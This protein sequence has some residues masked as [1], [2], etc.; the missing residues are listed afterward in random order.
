[1]AL[2]I[3]GKTRRPICGEV[4]ASESET[5]SFPAFLRPTHPLFKYSDAVFHAT[6]FAHSPDRDTVERLYQRY[7]VIWENRPK[8]IPSVAEIEA[9]GKKAF[10]EFG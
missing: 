1:M 9:W 6:C 4:I 10:D 3:S 8:D 2:L 7:R 5:A